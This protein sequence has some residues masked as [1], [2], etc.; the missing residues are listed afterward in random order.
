MSA[1]A[2]GARGAPLLAQLLE[3]AQRAGSA[4]Q[5][6]A[7]EK[8]GELEH[9]AAERDALRTELEL[10]EAKLAERAGTAEPCAQAAAPQGGRL[11]TELELVEAK[12]AERADTAESRAQAAASQNERLHTELELRDGKLGSRTQRACTARVRWPATPG[13]AAR[14]FVDTPEE[15]GV[16]L[17]QANSGCANRSDQWV[18]CPG[19][20][21]GDEGAGGTGA[22][23][24]SSSSDAS[25]AMHE[26]SVHAEALCAPMSMF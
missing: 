21:P 18:V 17:W 14:E 19:A 4:L 26:A 15:G 23:S 24:S 8:V 12:L 3:Q 13:L 16:E 25:S 9:V 11:R 10:V 6:W 22:S 20:L 7:Q 2:G 5:A 1:G